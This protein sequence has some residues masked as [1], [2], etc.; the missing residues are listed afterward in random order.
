MLKINPE[1]PQGRFI[2]RAV[3]VLE[4]GGIIVYPTD[5]VYGIGCD[6]F[7][8][9]A[10]DRIYQIKGKSKKQP[11][12][13]IVPNL[14]D[15]SKYA[16]VSD[17]AYRLMRRI[18]PGPYTVVL[19]ATRMVPKK[20]A[21]VNKRTVGIRIPDNKVCMMLL[22]AYPNPIISTSANLSGSEILNDPEVIAKELGHLVDLILDAG[23][24]GL[25]PSTVID[26]TGEEPVVLR[27]GKGPFPLP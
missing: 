24:L 13:F 1:N 21:P 23:M 6:I 27:Q 22:E 8:K 9:K 14:K 15:I 25:E 5:T 11:L 4:R 7:N 10:I 2:R 3:E 16:Y 20:I 12:S 19:P 17:P 18:L 26:L